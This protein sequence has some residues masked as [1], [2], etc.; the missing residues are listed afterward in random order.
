[1]VK[2]MYLE[3]PIPFTN[4]G[5]GSIFKLVQIYNNLTILTSCTSDWGEY[6]CIVLSALLGGN[7]LNFTPINKERLVHIPFP[8][9][10]GKRKPGPGT[11]CY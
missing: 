2:S 3:K 5:R 11:R 1:M 10:K 6:I 4:L 7:K 9:Q 8:N